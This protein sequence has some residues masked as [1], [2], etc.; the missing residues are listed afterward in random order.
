MRI[1]WPRFALA[2]CLFAA[3]DLRAQSGAC[4]PGLLASDRRGSPSSISRQEDVLY[5]GAGAAVVVVDTG[6]LLA[7]VE[8][9]RVDLDELVLDVAH[10][11]TMVVALGA[12]GLSIIDAADG[13]H[14]ALAGTFAFPPGWVVRSVAAR[15]SHAFVPE[16]GGLHV[17]S[18]ADPADPVQV[19]FFPAASTRDVAVSGNR[20]YLLSAGVLRV[21]NVS[22]P[23]NPYL[24]ASVPVGTGNDDRLSI[25]GSGNRLAAWGSW[26]SGH[27]YGSGAELFSLADPALPAK[28]SS[29]FYDDWSFDSL[30][31][32]FD[33]VYVG[34][35]I[36]DV[37][38]LANPVPLGTLASL[39]WPVDAAIAPDPDLLF[40]AE[41][42]SG[43]HVIDVSS[44]ANPQIA[45]SVLMPSEAQDGYLAGS[46]AVLVRRAA[47]ET[48]DLSDPAHPAPLGRLTWPSTS[49]QEVERVGDHAWVTTFSPENDIRI[50][51]LS[52]PSQ[53]E[54]V[55]AV[56][57]YVWNAPALAGGIV[58]YVD[59]CADWLRLLDVADPGSPL[60]LGQISLGGSCYKTDFA[61]TAG[62]LYLWD[63]DGFD[64]DSRLR[65]FDLSDPVLP[66]ELGSAAVEPWHWGRSV[67]RG[68]RYLLLTDE[69]RFDVLDVADPAD[70]VRVASLSLPTG[71]WFARRLTTYGSRAL[72]APYREA[73]D[74]FDERTYL[75]DVADPLEPAVVAELRPPGHGRAAVAGPGLILIADGP[76]GYSIYSSCVPFADGFE[77]GDVSEWS[78]AGR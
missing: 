34:G 9:G 3:P 43:L 4:T 25:A 38:A 68:G 77:G 75:L 49:F 21:I 74:E 19:G 24:V 16:A 57:S 28:R 26:S 76:A 70:P 54:I 10:W 40:A 69:D 31:F 15:A 53:P 33:R 65:V 2:L 66:V 50:V 46:L 52:D 56:G 59:E 7:P 51:D 12:H 8:R 35:L 67:V 63:Y 27:H 64:G 44:P 6:D 71:N 41:A 58:G 61:M 13:D 29:L 45:A 17:V 23:A 39:L 78:L 72:V 32:A 37:S 11:Q 30:A 60:P 55:G 18:F 62:R 47:L 36:Y 22:S 20:A 14:P 42:D 5:L 73:W 48:L 1:E